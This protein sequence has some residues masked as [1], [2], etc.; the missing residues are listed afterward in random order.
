MDMDGD[1]IVELPKDSGIKP[2][3]TCVN[4]KVVSMIEDFMFASCF[5]LLCNPQ[6]SKT[7]SASV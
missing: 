6:N 3:A 5:V 7:L 1:L 2:F 4:A